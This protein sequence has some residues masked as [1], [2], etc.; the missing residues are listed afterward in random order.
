M[1]DIKEED[2]NYNYCHR[3]QE[4]KAKQVLKRMTNNKAVGLENIPIKV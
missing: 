4:H 2:I 1:M 3:I